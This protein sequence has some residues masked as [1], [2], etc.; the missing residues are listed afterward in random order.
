MH[1]ETAPSIRP[2]GSDTEAIV[3]LWR[4]VFPEYGDPA[5]PQRDPLASVRRKVAFAEPSAAAHPTLNA[6]QMGRAIRSK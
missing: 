1:D 2:V 3:L 6:A 4:R 5:H